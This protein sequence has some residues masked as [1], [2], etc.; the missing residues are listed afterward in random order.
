MD[1]MSSTRANRVLQGLVAA[2]FSTFVALLS[3]VAGGGSV[4][5]V[6]GIVAP[7]VLSL[8]VCVALAGRRL[9]LA[10][11]SGSVVASQLLFHSLFV[12]GASTGAVAASTGAH[13]GHSGHIAIATT[14]TAALAGAS[15][16][17]AHAFAAVVTIAALHRGDV[18]LSRFADIARFVATVVLRVALLVAP[19]RIAVVD[20]RIP[21]LVIAP[22]RA[23]HAVGAVSRRGPP[24][25]SIA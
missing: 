7:L 1:H 3:H 11:L 15:M 17:G 4:P 20:A 2:A 6:L 18:L 19:V 22:R 25:L 13:A 21:D 24:L 23:V 12:L 5:G 9:A 10:R 16:W 8:P 14:G